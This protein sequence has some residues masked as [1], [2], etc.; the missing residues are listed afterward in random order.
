MFGI[1]FVFSDIQLIPRLLNHLHCLFVAV[2]FSFNYFIRP[3]IIWYV[4]QTV[5]PNLCVSVVLPNVR[6]IPKCMHSVARASSILCFFD[7]W[8][9]IPYNWTCPMDIF[10]SF[11]K[12]KRN[13]VSCF[14]FISIVFTWKANTINYIA[15]NA[16]ALNYIIRI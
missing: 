15:S 14:C 6:Y 3:I 11:S 7:K 4:T 13:F 10:Y 2:A 1:E 12:K 16:Y 8:S 5:I 9:F